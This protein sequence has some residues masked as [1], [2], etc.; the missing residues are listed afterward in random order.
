MQKTIIIKKQN[1]TKQTN[2]KQLQKNS[3]KLLNK[4][5]KHLLKEITKQKQTAKLAKLRKI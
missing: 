2:K 5:R 1:K 4:I 3:R